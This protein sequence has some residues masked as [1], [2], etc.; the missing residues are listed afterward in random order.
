LDD[1]I[2]FTP[3]LRNEAERIVKQYDFGVLYTPPSERGTILMPGLL[4]GASWAGAALDPESG[5]LYIPSITQPSVVRLKVPA[6]GTSN[7]NYRGSDRF[8]LMGPEGLPLTKP[9]YGRVT[10]IDLNTGEVKWIVPHGSGPR[11]HAKL[12]SLNLPQLGWSSRGFLLVT[13]TLLFAVQEPAHSTR[14]STTTNTFE[15]TATTREPYLRIFNKRT[16]D[17]VQEVALPANAGGAPITYNLGSQQY[18]VVPVGGGGVASEL[19]AL[20]LHCSTSER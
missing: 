2:D 15:F 8:P 3:E 13:K 12:K 14:F 10:A 5:W 6:P 9:P 1:L 18:V 20:A 7:M 11:D 17:L 16:G 19:V 4:G